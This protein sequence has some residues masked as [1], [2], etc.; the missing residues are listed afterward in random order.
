MTEVN[1]RNIRNTNM[2]SCNCP[3]CISACR[4]DPGRLLPEDLSRLAK[5]LHITEKE[6]LENYLVRI[7]LSIK[8]QVFALA[9][10]KRKGKR[11]VAQPGSIAQDYYAKEHGECLFLDEKGLCS[12][13]EAKP[14]ECGA[15]MGCTHTFL[16]RVYKEKQVEEYFLK[17][18]KRKS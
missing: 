10:A 14:F 16:G 6:L 7:P 11:F 15:Y 12:V 18:W 8:E 4:N 1:P 17:R 3:E 5:F 13:H 2:E 9:P